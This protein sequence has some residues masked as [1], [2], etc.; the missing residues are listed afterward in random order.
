M[1][2]IVWV[3]IFQLFV[4]WISSVYAWTCADWNKE[5]DEACDDWN[6]VN[7][8]GCDDSCMIEDGY[9]CEVPELEFDGITQADV[10]GGGTWVV[11]PDWL[12]ITETQNTSPWIVNVEADAMNN[13]YKFRFWVQ[14]TSDDDMIWIALGYNQWEF[15]NWWWYDYILYDRKQNSQTISWWQSAP[16]WTRLWLANWV[17]TSPRY[18][19]FDNPLFWWVTEFDRGDVYGNSWR[20]D[21]TLYD[22]DVLYT[23]TSLKIRIDWVLDVDITPSMFPT[24]FPS[25]LFP[26]WWI[27][28]YAYSQAQARFEIIPQETSFCQDFCGNGVL[29]MSTEECDDENLIAN[30]GCSIE[31]EIEY[32]RD[33]APLNDTSKNFVVTDL[34]AWVISWTST[35]ANSKVAICF[36]DTTWSRDIFYTSTDVSGSFTYTPNLWPYLAPWVNIWV[37]L[38]DE[39]GLD[40]DH[41]ALILR[42]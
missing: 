25:G 6:L 29:N 20:A 4:F 27:G 8:D 19:W 36:E 34:S 17:N 30:D 10:D 31:C 23:T 15:S 22:L 26:I 42:N 38:H 3:T 14:T 35:Q 2:L 16:R 21:N 13:L 18:R 33:D 28:F 40:I 9:S 32:C 1:Q 5:I 24:E 7:G 12:W 39:N 11:D 37:M 41:H